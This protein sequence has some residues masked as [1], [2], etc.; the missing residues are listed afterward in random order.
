M[1]QIA[2]FGTL[3]CH[4]LVTNAGRR[5]NR[6]GDLPRTQLMRLWQARMITLK[7]GE[8]VIDRRVSIRGRFIRLWL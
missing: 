3:R 4:E 8:Q 2:I 1:R 7:R 6:G 5:K